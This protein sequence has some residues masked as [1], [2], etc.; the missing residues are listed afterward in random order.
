M[1]AKDSR[2]FH[3]PGGFGLQVN[4][5]SSCLK[6]NFRYLVKV[7]GG[8]P[9]AIVGWKHMEPLQQDVASGPKQ[10]DIQASPKHY[11]TSI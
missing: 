2:C 8:V 3:G 10:T 1:L 9:S 7:N 4:I 5:E 11:V 6:I